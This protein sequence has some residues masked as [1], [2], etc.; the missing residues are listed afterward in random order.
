MR[1]YGRGRVVEPDDGEW[2]ELIAGF[3]P[4]PGKRSVIILEIDRI[5]DSCG[6]AV[7]VYEYR[8]ERTQ[9]TE[10]ARRKGPSGLEQYKAQKNRKSID[11]LEGLARVAGNE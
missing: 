2:D 3:P 6:F 5:A 10:Y 8:H 11:G 7:P 4:H 9:L 1:L